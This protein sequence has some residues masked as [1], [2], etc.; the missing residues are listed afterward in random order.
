MELLC[1]RRLVQAPNEIGEAPGNVREEVPGSIWA[2]CQV[3]R[4]PD[5]RF[6]L[7]YKL[8]HLESLIYFGA[9]V[10]LVIPCSEAGA[11]TTMP[12]VRTLLLQHAL[13]WPLRIIISERA[14]DR[15][16]TTHTYVA[17]WFSVGG[18]LG[19]RSLLPRVA[20]RSCPT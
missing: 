5:P 19:H 3:R 20:G 11:V 15:C 13:T 9:K 12:A 18:V 8:S 2:S 6:P 17:D 16:A 7:L 4:V 10:A 14:C 1:R